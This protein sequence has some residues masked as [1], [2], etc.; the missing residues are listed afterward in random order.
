[1]R[2]PKS[3]TSDFPVMGISPL[4]GNAVEG[5][6]NGFAPI[7]TTGQIDVPLV[8]T[9]FGFISHLS[10][11]EQEDKRHARALAEVTRGEEAF[12]KRAGFR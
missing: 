6:A 10:A 8:D 9:E 4:G 5:T 2:N 11:Q 1:M 12:R 7:R 3:D